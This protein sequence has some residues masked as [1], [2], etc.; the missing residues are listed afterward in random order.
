MPGQL[1][2]ELS[3]GFWLPFVAPPDLALDKDAES[4]LYGAVL[5]QLGYGDFARFKDNAKMSNWS[6]DDVEE[7]KVAAPSDQQ[8][9]P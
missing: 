2:D 3:A 4:D 8:V 7:E 9:N 5:K 6:L 1:A